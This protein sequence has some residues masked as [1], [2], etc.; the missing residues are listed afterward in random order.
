MFIYKLCVSIAL[1]DKNQSDLWE[2]NEGW[3]RWRT[4]NKG[5]INTRIYNDDVEKQKIRKSFISI[6]NMKQ[7]SL[8]SLKKVTSNLEKIQ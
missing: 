4:W 1:R 8:A 7:C 2:C 6:L 3:L 5:N